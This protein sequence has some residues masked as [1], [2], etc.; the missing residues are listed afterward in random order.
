MHKMHGNE[1]IFRIKNIDMSRGFF[2]TTPI[3][4]LKNANIYVILW[5]N[6]SWSSIKVLKLCLFKK[7]KKKKII[8]LVTL[9]PLDHKR[10]CLC[11]FFV[12]LITDMFEFQ[13]SFKKFTQTFHLNLFCDMRAIRVCQGIIT[14]AMSCLYNLISLDRLTL[15]ELR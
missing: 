3:T 4:F 14:C 1:N 6:R 13:Q 7:K 2:F 5:K 8:N 12:Y 9:K 10:W 15:K 11:V